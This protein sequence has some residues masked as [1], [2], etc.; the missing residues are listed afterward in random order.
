MK[1]IA[2]VI[3]MTVVAA[4]ANAAPVTVN[5]TLAGWK[6][7]NAASKAPIPVFVTKAGIDLVQATS[8]GVSI[9]GPGAGT[10]S[11]AVTGTLDSVT[12]YGTLTQVGSFTGYYDVDADN[13]SDDSY[14]NSGTGGAVTYSGLS[15][16]LDATGMHQVTGLATGCDAG[17]PQCQFTED[18]VNA[19]DHLNGLNQSVFDFQ[20]INAGF[21]TL[22][23]TNISGTAYG[24]IAK[25][26]AA[27]PGIAG[28]WSGITYT[29]N[30]ASRVNS[31]ALAT[32][33]ANTAVLSVQAV[34]VPAAAWLMGSGLVGLAGI[35]RR[36]K[37]A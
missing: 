10:I 8:P 11:I 37:M 21:Q 14:A 20:G 27:T 22:P 30:V 25:T 19:N 15:W 33:A 34:P 23:K 13:V 17:V 36:R 3:A 35:A 18:G 6:S 4:S 5:G 9:I 12:G 1:K 2:A 24:T 28:S 32:N 7:W 26:W 16:T 29:A 31:G